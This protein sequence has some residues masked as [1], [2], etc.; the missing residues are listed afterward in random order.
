M[1]FGRR[2]QA[3]LD[4]LN[5]QQLRLSAD[6]T[7]ITFTHA[8]P[9]HHQLAAVVAL[10]AYSRFRCSPLLIDVGDGSC[11]VEASP[12]HCRRLCSADKG[13][14]HGRI[15]GGDAPCLFG[16]FHPYRWQLL[17]LGLAEEVVAPRVAVGREP[18]GSWVEMRSVQQHLAIMVDLP[19]HMDGILNAHQ[20][21]L[22][23]VFSIDLSDQ[24]NYSDNY[25]QIRRT[26]SGY[27]SRIEAQKGKANPWVLFARQQVVRRFH[28]QSETP[29][30]AGH[31]DARVRLEARQ[32]HPGG[33]QHEETVRR[34][35]AA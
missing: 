14:G 17:L 34:F 23:A 25:C 2:G 3:L 18:E 8:C 26:N 27:G 16:V 1:L 6:D 10:Y 15:V 35:K 22:A 31:F 28:F 30:E 5:H 32:A 21:N 19:A 9:S 33:R 24:S 12:F 11:V 7:V 29:P 20:T 13:Q 4:H